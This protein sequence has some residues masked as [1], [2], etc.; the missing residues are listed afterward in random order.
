MPIISKIL[1]T[2]TQK[3]KTTLLLSLLLAV[4]CSSGLT[5][6]TPNND[7]K[8]FFQ[9]DDPWLLASENIQDTYT[10]DQNIMLVVRNPSQDLF[11]QTGMQ[12]I[13]QATQTAWELPFVTR[14]DS[15][16]NFQHSEA[17]DDDLFIRDLIEEEPLMAGLSQDYITRS[18]A[19]A[20]NEPQLVNRLISPDGHTAGVNLTL[21]FQTEDK[22]EIAAAAQAARQWNQALEKH[23]PETT[24]KL[25]G[26][27]MTNEAIANASEHDML[28]LGPIMFTMMV[29][30]MAFL[31]RSVS[32]VIG[33]VLVIVLSITSG[34]GLAGWLGY[35]MTPTLAIAPTMMMTMAIADCVHLVSGIRDARVRQPLVPAILTGVKLNALPITITSLT[36][37]IGFLGMRVADNPPIVHLGTVAAIGVTAA[38]IYSLTLL[39]AWLTLTKASLSAQPEGRS[40][41]LVTLGNWVISQRRIIIVV[42]LALTAFMAWS[43]TRNQATEDL[44]KYFKKSTEIRQATEFSLDHLTGMYQ[45]QFSLATG[46]SNGIA[47]PDYLSTL[48]E[49]SKWFMQQEGVLQVSHV[50]DIVKRLNQNMHSDQDEW[51]RVPEARNL[52]AQ[53]LLMYQ[54]SLPFGLTL[55][56]L[57]TADFD[58]SRFVVTL[59]RVESAQIRQLEQDAYEWLQVNA[60]ELAVNGDMQNRG[61]GPAMMYAHTAS[62]ISGTMTKA[63]FVALLGISILLCIALRSLGWGLLSMIPNIVPAIMAFG[64]WGWVNGHISMTVAMVSTMTLGIVVDD[65]VHFLSKYL[66][67]RRRFQFSPKRALDYAYSTVGVALVIT[68][69]VLVSGFAVMSLSPFEPSARMSE[70]ALI[71]ITT[72]LIFDLLFLPALIAT[73]DRAKAK[74]TDD[75]VDETVKPEASI[76]L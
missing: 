51:Y 68:T 8:A 36:T 74:V 62:K 2:V 26:I 18:K 46:E 53:Y 14:V 11:T 12:C 72:A 20:L 9:P 39:P 66:H 40:S 1:P 24:R 32:A 30:M 65:T 49:F 16:A 55:E 42:T 43:A 33:S 22:A 70:L 58:A 76:A 50:A 29:I 15:I 71:T 57:V 56:N 52:A 67:A 54:M 45:I 64:I 6:L 7:Y 28:V 44:V 21:H 25:A 37:A 73:V 69:V 60:P 10:R 31:F 23:C 27:V 41:A 75:Q 35:E 61:A 17:V 13:W 59:G 63:T 19:A 4:I 38:M 3:P 47:D 34:L 48:D 5:Q